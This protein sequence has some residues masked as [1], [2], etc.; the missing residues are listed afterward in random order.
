MIATA[1]AAAMS[2]AA[3]AAMSQV[4]GSLGYSKIDADGP[5]FDAVTGRLGLQSGR[6]GVDGE[7]SAGVND[8]TVTRRHDSCRR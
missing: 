3:T 2:R 8:E 6:F 4:H 1:A 5:Q 7:A